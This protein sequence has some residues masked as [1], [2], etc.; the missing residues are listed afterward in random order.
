MEVK[1]NT[2][3]CKVCNTQTNCVPKNFFGNHLYEQHKEYTSDGGS[4]L[5]YDRYFKKEKE[6]KCRAC[7]NDTGFIKFSEGYRIYCSPK[8]ATNDKSVQQKAKDTYKK[9]TGYEHNSLNPANWDKVKETN[10]K[11]I[12]KDWYF[13]TEKSKNI[14]RNIDWDKRNKTTLKTLEEKYGDGIVNV[15]QLKSVKEKI[16]ETNLEKY[17]FEN[18]TQNEVVKNKIK[19]QFKDKEKEKIRI[20][21]ISNTKKIKNSVK[22]QS[23]LPFGYK[24]LKYDPNGNIIVCDKGHEFFAQTQ[25]IKIR[26]KRNEILCTECNPISAGNFSYKEKELLDFIKQNYSGEI[27]DNTRSII[28]PLELDIYLPE[29]KLAFEFNGIHWHNEINKPIDYHLNKTN[30]CEEKGIHLVH[31]YEDDWENKQDIIKS[32]ILNLLHKTNNNIGARNCEIKEI[33]ISESNTFL[34]NNHIQGQTN[35]K[36]NVGLYYNNELVS[37]MTFGSLRINLGQSNKISHYELL[38]FCNKL[39][40]NVLGSAGKLFKY[41]VEKYNPIEILS[42]ADRSWSSLLNNPIYFKLGFVYISNTFPNYYYVVDGIRRNRFGFRKSELIKQ[43]FDE[44]KTEHEIM[45]ERE[46]YRVYDSGSLKFLYKV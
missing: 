41:F 30:I 43:G 5:Y 37:L 19:E 38:R 24:I 46:I 25:Y 33:D 28:Y 3:F 23:L 11:K 45:I 39:N 13:Q 16:I 26:N 35:S 6:G 12:G 4:K 10:Q 14:V 36:Y 15:F 8:C 34:S 20:D 40:T 7:G 27:Q 31:I 18:A 2:V 42:Y 17:G 22:L 44:T 32:R 29:L 1:S 9:K 21:K